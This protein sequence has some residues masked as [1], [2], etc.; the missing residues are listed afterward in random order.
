MELNRQVAERTINLR[1]KKRIKLGDGIIAATALVHDL[2]L[3]T[4]NTSDFAGIEGLN[5]L[6]PFQQ[7]NKDS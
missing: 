2:T 1:R 5:V 3:V 7:Q 4:R 6:N